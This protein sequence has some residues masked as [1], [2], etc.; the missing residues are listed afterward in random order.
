MPCQRA[1]TEAMER[2]ANGS[3]EPLAR[4]DASLYTV[5]MPVS[6]RMCHGQRPRIKARAV[7]T[8]LHKRTCARFGRSDCA[9]C[10]R[11]ATVLS[12]CGSEMVTTMRGEGRAGS[13]R[14]EARG[15]YRRFSHG[16]NRSPARAGARG[17]AVLKAGYRLW[18]AFACRVFAVVDGRF[19]C[20]RFDAGN[21]VGF[22]WRYRGA[23]RSGR[24]LCPCR[25]AYHSLD[26]FP[27]RRCI[28]ACSG[29]VTVSSAKEGDRRER[30]SAV[31]HS[32]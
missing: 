31:Y 32:R 12:M 1:L 26:W 28:V 7:R 20:L 30:L 21:G 9:G 15:Y 23:W 5:P 4:L 3:R 22:G 18:E 14:C 16:R 2:F 24:L 13:W 27:A 25:H 8:G 6:A 29:V 11:R 17:R 19:G 10:L